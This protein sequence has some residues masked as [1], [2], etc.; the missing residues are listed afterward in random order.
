MAK[1]QS[2]KQVL[3]A[4]DGFRLHRLEILNWGTFDENVHVFHLDGETALLVGQ[5]GSGKST[6]VD[7]VL[8]LMVPSVIRNYN[9]AAGSKKRERSEVTYIQGAYGQVGDEDDD[10]KTKPAYHRPK[11]NKPTILLACFRNAALDQTV[12][13][14]HILYLDAEGRAA[15][16]VFCIADEDRKIQGDIYPIDIADRV[17]P[18]LKE[19]GFFA[20]REFSEYQRRFIKTFRLKEKAMDVFNQT[21]AVKDIENL[22]KFIRQHMLDS[23]PKKEKIDPVVEHFHNLKV[24]YESLVRVRKQYELLK[25]LKKDGEKY[26]KIEEEYN[27]AKGMHDSGDVF[28]AHQ[29]LET[30]VPQRQQFYNGLKDLEARIV[31]L[32]EKL[33]KSRQEQRDVEIALANVGGEKRQLLEKDI[34]IQEQEYKDKLAKSKQYH[35][36]LAEIGIKERVNNQDAFLQIREQ[37]VRKAEEFKKRIAEGN[38]KR[39]SRILPRDK[40]REI[41]ESDKQELAALERRR[42]NLPESNVAMRRQICEGLNLDEKELPFA[43]ELIAVLPDEFAWE[44]SI[45]KLLRNFALNLLVPNDMYARVSNFIEKNTMLDQHKR[46]GLLNY[47]LAG[48]T[49]KSTP[50][51][52]KPD[53]V[54]AKLNLKKHALEPW[55]REELKRRFDYTCCKDMDSFRKTPE[56]AMTTSRHIKHVG[57]RHEKDDRPSATDRSNFVLGWDNKEKRRFLKERIEETQQR[58][59]LYDKQI[60]DLDSTLELLR[61]RQGIVERLVDVKRFSDIDE[62]P[63][64]ETLADL[65]KQLDLLTKSNERAK[66]L[67]EQKNKIVAAIAQQEDEREEAVTESGT[68]KGLIINLDSRI[69]LYQKKID[70]SQED[71]T[72]P[73]YEQFF[74]EWKALMNNDDCQS[75]CAEIKNDLQNKMNRLA[76]EMEP[77]KEKTETQMARFLVLFPDLYADLTANI[78]S[79]SGFERIL[80]HIEQEDL[81]RHTEKFREYLDDKVTLELQSLATKLKNEE[82]EIRTKIDILNTSLRQLEYSPGTYMQL[83]AREANDSQINDFRRKMGECI[84]YTF[85]ASFAVGEE[86]Y[87]KLEQLIKEL[88]TEEHWTEK[89]LD[90][91]R[92]FTFLARELDSTTGDTKRIL[93][94]SSGQ[95]GGEKA[96][97][98]FTILVASIAYQY[99]IDPE[100]TPSD[101]FHF[102]MVDEMFSKID[103]QFSEYALELFAKF[104]LQLLIVAPLDAKARV[105]EPFVKKY[106][107]VVKD[108]KNR[109]RVHTMSAIEFEEYVD[110]VKAP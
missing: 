54:F 10:T 96:K 4:L 18:K 25:P 40:E 78:S 69:G 85:E 36:H 45:E 55:L 88:E 22:N 34:A 60:Q 61:Y 81:P 87:K 9:V 64:E 62:R 102:V 79:L 51:D 66:F 97:L 76:N 105:T 99:D 20:C 31:E 106:L 73:K 41:L 56:R 104:R 103:D 38:E 49:S 42:S 12:T 21:V 98:A 35:G 71:G 13:L 28:E 67:N 16:H 72:F 26:R 90:V 101:R 50:I 23:K 43:A 74:G 84:D 27:R 6:L 75:R 17:I 5:N 83:E 3:P 94:D 59:A 44:S 24:A 53:G 7:A 29:M 19:K 37:I 39:D 52:E 58:I 93:E 1:Q 65:R 47:Q 8:T 100:Q 68:L 86:R 48:I 70:R 110:E 57:K 95:S 15:Q 46:G 108:P 107:H 33:E 109:S 77:V 30:M 14:A 82:R 63:H 32:K 91:R 92:W 11:S 89:V 2:R 80:S